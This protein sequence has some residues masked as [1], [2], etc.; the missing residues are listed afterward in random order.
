MMTKPPVNYQGKC[1]IEEDSENG[2]LL[3]TPDGQVSGHATT[4]KAKKAATRW[5][6]ENMNPNDFNFGL[7]EE[8]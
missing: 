7:I 4:A 2:V 5:F 6:K 8:R 3:M 1:V